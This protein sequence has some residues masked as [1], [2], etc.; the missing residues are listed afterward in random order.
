MFPV[1]SPDG[2]RIL[3]ASNRTGKYG[4]YQKPVTGA[5]KEEFLYESSGV[6][7]PTDWSQDG[8]LAIF[9]NTA[10]KTGN[11]I[12][13]LPLTGDRKPRP[14]LETE[15]S[16]LQGR[17]SPDGRWLAYESNETGVP[18]VFVQ[19]FPGAE[20]K[21]QVSA[22]GGTRPVWSRDGKELFYV[23]GAN[24]IMAV[25]VKSDGKF[26]YGVPK[27]LF[28]VHMPPTGLFDV[29]RDGKRF[30]VLNGAEPEA[31]TPMTLVIHWNAGL[32]K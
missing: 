6:T 2:S 24:K 7:L 13:V 10:T 25:E 28:G 14:F 21:W 18:N 8:R 22:E 3:F 17:M 9:Y 23:S 15:F 29:T 16:E 11:D 32:R 30:L 1:W 4:L 31:N 5:G 26:E 27:V 20:G 12:W 19:T